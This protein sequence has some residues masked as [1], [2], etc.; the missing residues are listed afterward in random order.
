MKINK[1]MI[2]VFSILIVAAAVIPAFPGRQESPD[3]QYE[4]MRKQMASLEQRIAALEGQ[5]EKLTLAIPQTFPDLK[6]MPKGWER[7]EFNGMNYYIIPIDQTPKRDK[8]II[9]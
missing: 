6:Q 7:R 1:W 5:M 4:E 9:R 3:K 2:G 8:T